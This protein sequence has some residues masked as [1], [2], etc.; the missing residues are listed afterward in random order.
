MPRVGGEG[1]VLLKISKYFYLGLGDTEVKK[2]RGVFCDNKA[3][4]LDY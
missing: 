4:E 3:E 1:I 2:G